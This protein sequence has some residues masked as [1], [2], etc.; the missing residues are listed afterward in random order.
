[1]EAATEHATG[2]V[3][4][5]DATLYS[6]LKRLSLRA[7]SAAGNKFNFKFKFKFNFNKCLHLVTRD[8]G[9]IDDSDRMRSGV[10]STKL[11]VQHFIARK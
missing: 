3:I 2:A 8:G 6:I 11:T 9:P 1:M 5:G 10:S 4:A 7:A